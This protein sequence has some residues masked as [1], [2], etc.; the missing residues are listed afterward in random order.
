MYKYETHLHTME[1]S[2]CG[3]V[4]ATDQVK[5]YKELGYTGICVTDHLHSLYLELMDCHDDWGKCMDRWLYGYRLAKAAGEEYGLNVILGMELRF[6][7]NESDYLI[8]GI[9]EKWVYGH[10]WI[11]RMDHQTFFD[12]Y[13]GEVLIIHAHPYRNCDEVFHTCVHGLEIANCN[14]RHP[15]RNELAL[16]LARENPH[17]YPTVGSDAH[18]PGDEGRAAVCFERII[19]DSYEYKIAIE[20]GSYRL[21]CPEY[22]EIIRKSE[23]NV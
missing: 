13:G 20:T 4:R 7:E 8:Y 3:Y 14:P 1:T 5:T 2:R 10:P 6:P 15:S 19:H 9:D 12:T 21:W 22:E 23:R 18:R 17:L 16:Q 11:N